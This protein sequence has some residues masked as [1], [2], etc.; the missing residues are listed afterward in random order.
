METYRKTEDAF[1]SHDGTH[2][3]AY[4][5]YTPTKPPHAIVQIAHGMAEH[6]GRYERFAAF[7]A[8]QG[9]VVCGNDHLGHGK[10]VADESE[11]GFFGEKDGVTH[12]IAD[13]HT[14]YTKLRA[15]YPRLPYILFGHSMGSFLAREYSTKYGEEL[16]GAIYCG[17]S[18]GKQ[19]LW[20]GKLVAKT[21]GLF[22]G[23]KHRSPLI[24]K[25]SMGGYDKRFENQPGNWLTKDLAILERDG[26]DNRLGFAFTAAG[27]YDLFSLLARVS[28]TEWANNIPRSLPVLLVS[29]CDDP[30]GDWG[31]GVRT[32]YERLRDVEL[33]SLALKLYPGDRHEILNELD[34]EQVFVDIL[35]WIEDVCNGYYA[36][37]GA[38]R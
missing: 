36:A 38:A 26:A 34:C 19:P 27:Y 23:K 14:L 12:V 16:A 10:S 22:C 28:D 24:A 35:A 4:T 31:E 3:I 15:T 8:E 5:V 2:Q 11:F 37:N 9:I 30:V 1:L 21:V 20:L 18:A 25:L 32:V 13:M 7:L 6:F 33:C 17:T 29:G